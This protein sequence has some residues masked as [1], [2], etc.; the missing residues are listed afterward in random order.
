MVFAIKTRLVPSLEQSL[1]WQIQEAIARAHLK[2]YAANNL[3]F[4]GT[5][6]ILH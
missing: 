3:L 5:G 1:H 6:L 4:I 2:A